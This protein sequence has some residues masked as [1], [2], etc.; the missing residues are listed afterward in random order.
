LRQSTIRFIKEKEREP[1]VI[2]SRT[3]LTCKKK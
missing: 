3:L 2:R 1:R